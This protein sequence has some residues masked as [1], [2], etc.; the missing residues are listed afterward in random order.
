MILK[1]KERGDAPQLARY[2]MSMRDN[3]HVEL[4]DVRGFVSDDLTGAFS[5]ADAIAK[6]TRCKN[7]LFSMS[8]NPPAGEKVRMEDFEVAIDRIEEKLGLENQPRA[9]VF[10]EKDGRRHAHVVWSRIDSERMRALNMAHFKMKL[11]DVSRKLFLDHGWD[12]PRGL[13]DK[14]LRD[15]LNFS[16]EEWQ[17][18]RR[19]GIDPREL[20]SVLRQCWER[21][22]NRPS[23]ERALKERGFWLAGGD[24]RGFVAIDYRGEVYSLS[25]Y[26]GVKVKEL[27]A[28]IGDPARLRSVDQTKAEVA[29]GMT[30]KLEAFIADAQR[31]A[32]ERSEELAQRKTELAA[33]H[34]AEHEKLNANL[35][36]RWQAEVQRRAQRLPKGFSGIWHRLT[37]Q[38]AKLRKQN[39]REAL[40]AY[41][42]D[43]AAKDDLIFRQLEERGALQSYIRAERSVSQQRLALLREDVANYDSLERGP[44]RKQDDGMGP[45]ARRNRRERRPRQRDFDM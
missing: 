5:E 35:E 10:H 28:R 12:M 1:A 15:P 37:G 13:Q 42:R 3:E 25:R 31:E 27:E 20:K 29:A 33:R 4:H 26:A 43:R 7:Y 21:S 34:R 45:E 40:D 36:R 9:V 16:Q 44:R 23:F 17:Q 2:L 41:R 32:N 6:G 8:L 19:V 22:D 24:R 39:E 14:S 38:Y 11:R 30:G 18:A